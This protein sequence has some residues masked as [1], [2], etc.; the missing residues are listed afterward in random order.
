MCP[1]LTH[2]ITAMERELATGKRD[3]TTDRGHSFHRCVASGSKRTS[4][5]AVR[6]RQ[7]DQVGAEVR[8]PATTFDD[9]AP[10]VELLLPHSHFPERPALIEELQ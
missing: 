1:I 3:H 10:I 9:G 6:L 7:V 4:R 5:G 2:S 8:Q